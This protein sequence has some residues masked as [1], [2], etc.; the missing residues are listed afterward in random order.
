M[1]DLVRPIDVEE[2]GGRS[3]EGGATPRP[4]T[5]HRKQSIRKRSAARSLQDYTSVEPE[6]SPKGQECLFD[7]QNSV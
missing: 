1:L 2:N 7:G 3:R 4:R 6:N 5:I